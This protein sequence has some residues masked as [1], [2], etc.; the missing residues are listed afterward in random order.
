[1]GTPNGYHLNQVIK[2]SNT[3]NEINW[4]YVPPDGIQSQLHDILPKIFLLESIHDE[5]GKSKVW[6][7]SARLLAWTLKK[8]VHE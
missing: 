1:M 8:I 4:H 6:G 5:K 7:Y 3:N 2:F